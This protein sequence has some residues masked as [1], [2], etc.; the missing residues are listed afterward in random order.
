MAEHR[1][2]SPQK[3][4]RVTDSPASRPNRRHDLT[5]R[6][7]DFVLA[8]GL[9]AASLRPLAAA[10]GVS[11]RM[12]LYYFTDKSTAIAASL[13]TLGRRLSQTL[14]SRTT[15]KPLPM[16]RLRTKLVRLVQED[17]LWPYMCLWLDLAALAARGD[18]DCRATGQTFTRTLSS[19]IEAQLETHDPADAARLLVQIKGAV[20]GKA[21]GLRDTAD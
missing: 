4:D 17:A 12:L 16:G 1:Q 7:A 14:A 5:E 13:D 3:A 19:W 9:G 20:V 6:M 2:G 10:V 21:L 18:A 15:R 8:H 11:D